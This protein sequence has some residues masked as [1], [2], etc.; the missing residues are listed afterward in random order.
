MNRPHEATPMHASPPR[1]VVV[2]SQPTPLYLARQDALDNA[3]EAQQALGRAHDYLE[4]AQ[5]RHDAALATLA[6][7][8]DWYWNLREVRP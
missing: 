5:R 7:L 4:R 3:R 8:E 6:A 2:A 1:P